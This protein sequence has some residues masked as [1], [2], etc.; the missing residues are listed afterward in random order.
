M[1]CTAES[2]SEG[3]LRN[4]SL[5][6]VPE[7]LGTTRKLPQRRRGPEEVGAALAAEELAGSGEEGEGKVL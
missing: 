1:I 4:S 7:Q 2:E 6:R 3:K 5:E